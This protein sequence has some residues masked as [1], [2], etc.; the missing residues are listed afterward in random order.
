[1]R[2]WGELER[3]YRTHPETLT[4]RYDRRAFPHNA[5]T[6]SAPTETL[7][8]DYAAQAAWRT[9][10]LQTRRAAWEPKVR[11]MAQLVSA[12]RSD[13]L[14]ALKCVGEVELASAAQIEVSARS[15]PRRSR[16]AATGRAS[17]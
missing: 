9:H 7:H 2:G 11:G 10:E 4:Y 12:R 3:G 6:I 13:D 14:A 15:R 1:M 17:S 16:T 8:D 5:R